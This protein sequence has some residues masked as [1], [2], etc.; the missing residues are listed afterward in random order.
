VEAFLD[1]LDDT[2]LAPEHTRV[3]AEALLRAAMECHPAPERR[4][5]SARTGRATRS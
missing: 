2:G 1:V 5:R 3:D 4:I